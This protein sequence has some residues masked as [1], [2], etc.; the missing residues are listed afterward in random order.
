MTSRLLLLATF[1]LPPLLTAAEPEFLIHDGKAR[2]E[3]VI[4]DNP[5][6]AAE[7]GAQELQK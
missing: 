6:R 2:A 3:I 5:A 1:I 7:F 4:A